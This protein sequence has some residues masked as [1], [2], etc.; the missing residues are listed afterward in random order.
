[1]GTN[2]PFGGISLVTVGDL[3]QLKPV[4]DKWS[5]KIPNLAIMN[6]QLTFGQY[7]TG[8]P[9][10]QTMQTADCRLRTVQ[11]MQTV[12]TVQTVQTEYLFF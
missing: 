8:H 3:S 10:T 7:F 9:K 12:Q 1:M 2:E 4:F 11:T 6:L 5:L